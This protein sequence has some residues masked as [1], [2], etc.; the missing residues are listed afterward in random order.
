MRLYRP[1]CS[2]RSNS[3]VAAIQASQGLSEL[4]QDTCVHLAQTL[5][6]NVPRGAGSLRPHSLTPSIVKYLPISKKFCTDAKIEFGYFGDKNIA[7]I[8]GNE[9]SSLHETN[10]LTDT[11]QLTTS[12]MSQLDDGSSMP[13]KV[14][15]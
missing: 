13:G 14:L 10:Q 2:L 8:T 1:Q 11:P 7:V 4:R 15:E 3:G 9:A 12:R 5:V 6:A